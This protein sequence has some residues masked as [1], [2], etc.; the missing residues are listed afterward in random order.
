MPRA[1][2]AGDASALIGAYTRHIALEEAALTLARR[3]GDRGLEIRIR[4]NLAS[5][6]S[7][8]DPI[9][10]TRMYQ[11]ARELAALDPDAG[12]SCAFG[13]LLPDQVLAALPRGIVNLH[14]SLLP[15]YRGAAPVQRAL[16]DGVEVTGV[17]TF[18]I[19]A[20]MDTGPMLLAAEV[21]V[22]PG[23]DAGSLTARLAEVGL[24]SA[25]WNAL[26][27][28]A[29]SGEPSGLWSFS[30]TPGA[31]GSSV[32]ERSDVPIHPPAP[33]SRGDSQAPPSSRSCM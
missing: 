4:N 18:V 16:L 7:V 5:A 33:R 30:S 29:E 17:T 9:R 20:G 22:E 26:R 23:E 15:A 19:D 12:C 21:P 2:P 3:T 6:I 11:E 1:L 24:S 8:D 28:L 31:S 25:R 27:R 14:F 32:P 10:A 13:Y